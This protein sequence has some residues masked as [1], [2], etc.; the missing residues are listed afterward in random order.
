MEYT[1]PTKEELLNVIF[2]V[3]AGYGETFESEEECEDFLFTVYEELCKTVN[4]DKSYPP[5]RM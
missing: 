2:N 1:N 5:V 3:A 4:P